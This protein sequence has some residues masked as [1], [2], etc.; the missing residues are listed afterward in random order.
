MLSPTPE[1]QFRAYSQEIAAEFLQTVVVVDDKAETNPEPKKVSGES[2]AADSNDIKLN[3][4][5]RGRK[6]TN[7]VALGREEE[8]VSNNKAEEEQKDEGH[9]TAEPTSERLSI[10]EVTTATE[11][12]GAVV[13]LEDNEVLPI[14]ALNQAFAQRGIVCGFLSPSATGS[15]REAIIQAAEKTAKRADIVILDW[16]MEGEDKEGKQDGYTAKRI[17][18]G[19][20]QEDGDETNTFQSSG[21]LR[22][23]VI[24]SQSTVLGDIVDEIDHSLRTEVTP[25]HEFSRP[26]QYTLAHESTRICAFRKSGGI[27]NDGRTYNVKALTGRVIEE[28]ALLTEGLLSNV[29]IA[30]LSALR[31][32]THKILQK[33][34]SNLDTAYL[35]HRA[36]TDPVEETQEHPIALLASEMQ[37]VLAGN[38][39]TKTIAPDQIRL[40]VDSLPATISLNSQISGMAH[41]DKLKLLSDSII[42][43]ANHDS[44][45]GKWKSLIGSVKNG[46]A[47]SKFT[48][49][50][51][52]DKTGSQKDREFAMLTTVRSHYSAPPPYL[53]LGTIVAA[54]GDVPSE[55]QYYVCIQPVCDCVRLKSAR[56]FPFLKLDFPTKGKFDLVVKDQ[57]RF[58][59]LMVNYK[60]HEVV[61]LRF[62]PKDK[63]IKAN[64]Q[65][66]AF[67]FTGKT[68]AGKFVRCYWVA[69]LKTA[70]AQRIAEKF[71][72][73]ISRVG[74]TE[75][76]WLRRMA[77]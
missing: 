72:S 37:D 48:N 50:M 35:N 43:G 59:D 20:L 18:K 57:G 25:A 51:L 26:D 19:I 71:G 34:N 1:A 65:N 9:T 6:T 36:W 60:P 38:E 14:K 69:D 67:S 45:D 53:T 3:T 15:D 55:Y 77:S 42:F 17:I 12:E 47:E 33:F 32:N 76:E 16:K 41:K 75:S 68:A 7:G 39:V 10:V 46:Q 2:K 66:G 73:E 4:P 27:T 52:T 29:A 61:M 62:A 56:D 40:W 31:T 64:K 58:I 44:G 22:L 23:I 54:L 49:L 30:A 63:L 11:I 8:T 5:K 21:R 70:H 13:P 74:L 24:Y 28:F